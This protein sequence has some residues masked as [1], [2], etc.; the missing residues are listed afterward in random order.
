MNK[1]FASSFMS[2][3]SAG[4]CTH[5][6]HYHLFTSLLILSWNTH[7]PMFR[8]FSVKTF[9]NLHPL[10]WWWFNLRSTHTIGSLVPLTF[11]HPFPVWPF[12]KVSV[13]FCV[14]IFFFLNNANS[15][16]MPWFIS[17]IIISWISWRFAHTCINTCL[18]L[19]LWNVYFSIPSIELFLF[20]ETQ[21]LSCSDR[22]PSDASRTPQSSTKIHL[23]HERPPCTD[24]PF[25]LFLFVSHRLHRFFVIKANQTK[26]FLA[27][28]QRTRV[29]RKKSMNARIWPSKWLSCWTLGKFLKFYCVRK[30]SSA[31]AWSAINRLFSSASKRPPSQGKV[32][33]V[34]VAKRIYNW[35]EIDWFCTRVATIV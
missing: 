17:T 34:S 11:S 8:S 26:N 19:L 6:F 24:D 14:Q 5:G 22:W 4:H 12:L 29:W 7:T 31:F 20:E 27:R 15:P 21:M 16:S 32:R 18:Q 33:S 30:V 1:F 25:D 10:F 13:F 28:D 35:R 3:T 23:Y 2:H 9:P